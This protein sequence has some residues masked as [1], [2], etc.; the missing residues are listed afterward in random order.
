MDFQ[1]ICDALREYPD[2]SAAFLHTNV[3]KYIE[4]IALLKPT[5]ALAF[6]QPSHQTSVPPL[7]L[8]ANIHEFL[9]DC[10][11]LPDETSVYSLLPPMRVCLDPDYARLLQSNPTVLR[12][13]ELGEPKSHPITVFSLE[14]SLVT[15]H[16]ATAVTAIHVIIPTIMFMPTQLILSELSQ[17][18]LDLPDPTPPWIRRS[19][20]VW[21]AALDALRILFYH[22][23]ENMLGIDPGVLPALN[24]ECWNPEDVEARER[25]GIGFISIGL[26]VGYDS[27][28]KTSCKPWNFEE[29]GTKRVQKGPKKGSAVGGYKVHFFPFYTTELKRGKKPGE[30][31]REW[32]K[33]RKKGAE[34]GGKR[35]TVNDPNVVTPISGPKQ[36]F[37]RRII[38]SEDL[39]KP[40]YGE[41]LGPVKL[42]PRVVRPKPPILAS[43]IQFFGDFGASNIQNW[44]RVVHK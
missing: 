33:G 23:W 41:K 11:N 25:E 20:M 30:K 42:L 38:S 21:G 15:R 31:R 19:G 5:H 8:P 22:C 4:I 10:F 44:T 28:P 7:T 2:V 18:G 39:E 34:K 17:V 13:R 12:D 3:V 16:C 26:Q 37:D 1:S 43:K 35:A 9:K 40:T 27:E 6:F 32:E 29:K 36:R 24:P 14:L